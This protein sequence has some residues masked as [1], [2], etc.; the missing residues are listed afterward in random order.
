M[1]AIEARLPDAGR[2]GGAALPQR[3]IWFNYNKIQQER[4]SINYLIALVHAMGLKP[5]IS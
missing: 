4:I 1:D 3:K 2:Q 5:M